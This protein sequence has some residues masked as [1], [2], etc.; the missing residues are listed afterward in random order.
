[1]AR[2]VMKAGFPLTVWAR[3]PE[4]AEAIRGEG[5]GWAESPADLARESDV[6]ITIVTN[7]PDVRE[8]VAGARGL[9][10]GAHPGLTVVDMSTIAPATSRELAREAGDRGVDFLDAPVSGGTQGAEAGTLTIMVGGDTGAFARVQPVLDA[11]GK[12]VLHV[13]PSGSG[14]VIKLVNNALVGVIA[15][16]TA[17]ALVMGAKAGAD[18]ETMARVVGLS[19]G[20]SWQLANQFP[21]RA[22][23][24]TFHPGFTTDLLAKDLDLALDLGREQ[25]TPIFFTALA[26]QLY[27]ES[28]AAGYGKDDYTAVLKVFE[29]VADVAV[30]T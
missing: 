8:V 23:S 13:G 29:A 7:S 15:G 19:A 28:Q 1:M 27:L 24:G 25:Q 6:V 2:N 18:V 17:E 4:R 3:R 5:A 21:L 20:A 12:N 11:M 10:A 9:L 16:A 30:R 14:E 26:R 22:F